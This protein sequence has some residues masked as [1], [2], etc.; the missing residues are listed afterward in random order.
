[1]ALRRTTAFPSGVFGPVEWRAFAWLAAF[2]RSLVTVATFP[3][4]N[5]AEVLCTSSQSNSITNYH[6]RG[7]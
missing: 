1:M 7:L 5:N 2:C 4:F 6:Y 3:V